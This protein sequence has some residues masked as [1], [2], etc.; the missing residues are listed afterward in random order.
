MKTPTIMARKKPTSMPQVVSLATVHM[1]TAVKPKTE[2]TE[3]SNS[4]AVMSSVMA[5]AIMPSS[6]VKAM[7][8]LMLPT[9]M[10]VADISVKTMMAPMRSANGPNS[11]L[12]SVRFMRSLPLGWL[13]MGGAAVVIGLP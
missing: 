11:G 2:P 13:W 8:L 12:A 5:R 7:R 10:K 4:P 3:R 1:M 9:E 6:G